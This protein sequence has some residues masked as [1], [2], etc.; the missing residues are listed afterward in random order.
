MNLNSKVCKAL[1]YAVHE[2]FGAMNILHAENVSVLAGKGVTL[3][4]DLQLIPTPL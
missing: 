3:N 2:Q 1:S 4:R